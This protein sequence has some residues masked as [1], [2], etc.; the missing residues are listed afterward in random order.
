MNSK[1]IAVIAVIIVVIAVYFLFFSGQEKQLSFGDGTK[2]INSLWE[3]NEVNPAYVIDDS[4]IAFSESN[5]ESLDNDLLLFQSSL[6]ESNE[7]KDI[8]ALKDFTEIHLL[9]VDELLLAVQLKQVKA[10]IES[11]GGITA[12]N[13]CSKK[14]DLTFLG[15]KT[16]ELNNK[17]HKINELVYAF[18][19]IHPGFEEQANLAG[20]I[21]NENSF[22]ETELENTIL[23]NEIQRV[24]Q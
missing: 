4:V 9:L 22:S 19:E 2:E 18:N 21:A 20:F 12:D 3:K 15:E 7:T 16:I 5:L 8:S 6:N 14:D 24:C 23:V 17:M 11:S 1:L 13:L 10:R